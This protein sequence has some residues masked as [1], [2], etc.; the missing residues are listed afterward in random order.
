LY[1]KSLYLISTIQYKHHKEENKL[2]FLNSHILLET[3]QQKMEELLKN[4]KSKIYEAVFKK[5][6]KLLDSLLFYC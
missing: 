5:L 4:K 6:T 3:A 1:S 2:P